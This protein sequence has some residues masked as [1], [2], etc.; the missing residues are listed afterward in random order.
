[1]KC[2]K[3]TS[4]GLYIPVSDGD[5][6]L[7]DTKQNCGYG[8]ENIVSSSEYQAVLPFDALQI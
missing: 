4:L 2:Q 3:E 6:F 1:M 5:H 7:A 8:T